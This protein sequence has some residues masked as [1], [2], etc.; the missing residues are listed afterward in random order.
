MLDVCILKR[1]CITERYV[2]KGCDATNDKFYFQCRLDD[3]SKVTLC[4]TCLRA[5]SKN[6]NSFHVHNS[7]DAEGI[8]EIGIQGFLRNHYGEASSSD[9]W[10]TARAILLP[11][12]ETNQQEKPDGQWIFTAILDK[13]GNII[14]EDRQKSSMGIYP[15][16]AVAESEIHNYLKSRGAKTITFE[17]VR[18]DPDN[19]RDIKALL[20]SPYGEYAW[21]VFARSKSNEDITKYIG[22][23]RKSLAS[24]GGS[25]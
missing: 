9:D 18:I 6:E 5:M 21:N 24:A 15:N 3:D 7:P 11:H 10:E 4:G 13:K 17:Y 19:W 22:N 25:F 2:C 14:E 23:I 12:Q 20:N 16:K 8:G 1:L